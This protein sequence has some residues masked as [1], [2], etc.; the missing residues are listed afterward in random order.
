MTEKAKKRM[1]TALQLFTVAVVI[2]GYVYALGGHDATDASAIKS[3]TDAI[4]KNTEY[5]KE[6]R[7]E[8]KAEIGGIKED[9]DKIKSGVGEMKVSQARVEE[10]V[11]WL[12][13][14]AKARRS[15][16]RDR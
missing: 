10:K 15:T 6:T 13:D 12:V 4:L 16:E 2:L 9:V 8:V 1:S 7:A 14:E 11:N 3:N 5:G